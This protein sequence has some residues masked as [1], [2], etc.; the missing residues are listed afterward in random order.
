M[1]HPSSAF[2]PYSFSFTSVTAYILFLPYP[3]LL[4]VCTFPSFIITLSKAKE[5]SRQIYSNETEISSLLIH[6]A[7]ANNTRSQAQGVATLITS[8]GI[9]VLYE[10]VAVHTSGFI[11]LLH[12]HI[13]LLCCH[14]FF[15]VYTNVSSKI[16]NN[17]LP[18]LSFHQVL[19]VVLWCAVFSTLHLYITVSDYWVL[20]L[21]V[22]LVSIFL[23][24][25]IIFVLHLK[26]KEVN[27]VQEMKTG[28]FII[29]IK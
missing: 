21:S 6:T 24:T 3:F 15:A 14:K 28:N 10:H 23:T 1:L 5:P 7:S 16:W 25:G 19:Y 22:S 29:I 18:R 11:D 4:S 12:S 27:S 17:L 26:K 8:S 13:H 2:L 20:C 9:R